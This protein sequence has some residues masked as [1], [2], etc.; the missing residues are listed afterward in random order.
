MSLKEKSERRFD[1]WKG[2]L[3]LQKVKLKFSYDLYTAWQDA[4]SR[5]LKKLNQ[6]KFFK[7][8]DRLWIHVFRMQVQKINGRN[9]Q[10]EKLFF[11]SEKSKVKKQIDKLKK[12][13]R[14]KWMDQD[15]LNWNKAIIVAKWKFYDRYEKNW[16]EACNVLVRKMNRRMERVF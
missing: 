14:K 16:D 13:Y 15:S 12:R 7:L 6:G 9:N 4:E 1:P 8:K 3:R 2:Y 10:K 5:I 11:R